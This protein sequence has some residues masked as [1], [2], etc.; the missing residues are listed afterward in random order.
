[1]AIRSSCGAG[2]A[3]NCNQYLKKGRSV[4]VEGGCR[5]AKWQDKEGQDRYTTEIVADRVQFV[6]GGGG[7][8]DRAAGSAFEEADIPPPAASGADDIPF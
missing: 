2:S 3:E 6:G 8:G 4:F 1:V 5:L 7:A